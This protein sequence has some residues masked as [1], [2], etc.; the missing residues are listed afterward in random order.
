MP[1]RHALFT[2]C[3]STLSHTTSMS[4]TL[5]GTSKQIAHLSN[6]SQ[7][8]YRPWYA[9]RA[10]KRKG[11]MFANW[12]RKEDTLH[13]CSAVLDIQRSL[14]FPT[15][16][17]PTKAVPVTSQTQNT[18]LSTTLG[19]SHINIEPWSLPLSHLLLLR[20]YTARHR[21]QLGL[22]VFHGKTDGW[23]DGN[24]TSCLPLIQ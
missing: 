3:V 23:Q 20:H 1:F 18:T 2:L 13:H 4:G 22:V 16:H 10:A 24:R 19:T 11:S 21:I 9:L 6:G 14:R 7:Y 5:C 8:L 17:A 15:I 12:P